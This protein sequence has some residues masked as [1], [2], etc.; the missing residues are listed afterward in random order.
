MNPIAVFART[1]PAATL[2]GVLDAVAA[3]GLRAVHFNL[4]CAG[5][6]A[7]P[8][9]LPPA[10]PARIAAAFA[11]RGLTMVGLSGTWN[12]IHPDPAHRTAMAR[13]CAALIRGC[14]ELGTAVVSLCTGTRDPQDMWRPHPDNREPAAWR[15]LRE[16]LE[17][18][19]ALAEEKGVVLAI[20]PEPANVVASAR[21]ARRLLEEVRSPALRVILDAANT[22]AADPPRMADR[23][24]EAFDLLGPDLVHVHA[25]E[26]PHDRASLA[27][28]GEGQLDWE[29]F[30]R[31]LD[32]SGFE[33][34]VVLHN[35]HAA[36]VGRARRFVEEHLVG[37]G[38]G[39]THPR[40]AAP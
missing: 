17:P 12:M 27:A 32:R 13:R 35:L 30:F 6:A 16:S 10:L 28:P 18:L 34:P 8:E 38:A 20:E 23:F 26:L 31:L 1:Y 40:N 3:D 33:G 2:E 39:N 22:A 29:L 4:C 24:A 36:A 21:H 19:V 7:L 14:G 37:E 11:Q 15:D 25:K 9:A 5:L